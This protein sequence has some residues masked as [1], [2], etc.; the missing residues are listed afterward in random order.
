MKQYAADLLRVASVIAQIEALRQ[1]IK[2]D[3]FLC[4]LDFPLKE[5]AEAAEIAWKDLTAPADISDL[6]KLAL[7]E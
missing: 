3:K 2:N 5:A 7:A 1:Q 6:A 4:D